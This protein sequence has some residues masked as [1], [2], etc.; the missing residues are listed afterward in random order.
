[1]APRLT[2]VA[3]GGAGGTMDS[4]YWGLA[5]GL[6]AAAATTLGAAPALVGP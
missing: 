2:L 5:G 1:M 6:V 3:E 4:I